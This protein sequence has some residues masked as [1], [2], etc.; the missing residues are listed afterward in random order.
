MKNHIS[1]F[2]SILLVITLS[3]SCSTENDTQGVIEYEVSYP[4]K[5]FDTS[6]EMFLP[7]TMKMTYKNNVYKNEISNKF[8]TS[9]MISDCNKKQMT[10]ILNYE[11]F[12][13]FTT[14]NE[15]ETKK[16]VNSSPIPDFFTSPHKEEILGF[17]CEKHYG[18]FKR[19]EDG[20]DVDILETNKIPIKNS[21]WCTQYSN[22]QGVL[23]GYEL[24]KFG[25]NMKFIAKSI[26]QSIEVSDDEFSIPEDCKEVSLDKFL[27][28]MKDIF[29]IVLN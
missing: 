15:E 13:I 6:L 24:E 12:N 16:M 1:H 3:C 27:W 20:H 26:D 10:L 19:L 8:L 11:K 4:V 18:I 21:N 5:N 25:M 17:K 28:K 7:K 14:L 9:I 2:I 23:L 29:S 22:F